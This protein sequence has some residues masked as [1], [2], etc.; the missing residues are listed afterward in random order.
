M[1]SPTETRRRPVDVFQRWNRKGH[2]YLGLYFLFFLWLF[3][4]TGLLLN[5]SWRFAEFWPNRKVSTFERPVEAPR[6]GNGVDRARALMR[7]IG[8][9]GEIEWTAPR[10]DS[11]GFVFRVNRP[12]RNY[13]V[14][15]RAGE[16]RALV[17]QTEIN[18]WG[19]LHVLHTFT[20][21]RAGDTRNTRDWM[22]TTLW[23]W[24]MDA[25]SAGLVLMVFSGIY[26]WLGL[27]SKRNAGIAVLLLGS[28]ICGL[29]VFGL[30]R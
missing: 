25:V 27:P 10:P 8:I 6:A 4:F 3:A 29:F 5:H 2:Y 11:A 15:V 1:P 19:I 21:A 28:V 17:E 16:G 13:Q 7:Q 23:V 26:V 14:T 24:S 9:D 22:L 20:G 30:V 18:T 12:G